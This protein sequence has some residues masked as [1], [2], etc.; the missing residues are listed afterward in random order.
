[1]VIFVNQAFFKN[2]L[3]NLLSR[4]IF[5]C[6]WAIFSYNDKDLEVKTKK[7]FVL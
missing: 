7:Y 1:M 6:F 4:Q 2:F 3:R 5:S